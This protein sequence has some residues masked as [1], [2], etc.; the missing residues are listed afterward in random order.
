MIDKIKKLWKSLGPGLITGAADDDPSGVATYAMTG[1]RLGTGAVWMMLYSL[2]LMI[3]IQEMSA[4]IGLSS[5][6]GLA[7]NLKRYY[8]K[9]LLIFLSTLII[10]ANVLNI[11]AN[12]FGMASALELITPHSSQILSWVIV[13]FI[14]ILIVLLPYKKIVST[15]KWL[16]LTLFA[17]MFASFMIVENWHIILGQLLV[18][19][20]HLNKD[21][22]LLLMAVIGTTVA[23][24]MAFWQSSE[25]AEERKDKLSPSRALVCKFRIFSD[26]E[27]KRVRLDTRVGMFFS[28]FIAFFIIALTGSVLYEAGIKDIETVE[29]IA[30]ALKPLAGDYA[31]YLFAMGIIGAGLLT[32]PILAGSVGYILSEIFNWSGS[33]N[34]P[35][36]KAPE[37]Y[38]VII[39]SALIGLGI[40]YTGINAVDAL[41]YTAVLNGAI[42]P[43][44]IMVIIHMANNPAIVGPNINKKSDNIWGYI[45]FLVMT[46]LTLVVLTTQIPVDKAVGLIS[47]FVF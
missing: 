30:N 8:P 45:A 16:A 13:V 18:P 39:F 29:D 35:F 43:L 24:Y 38:M 11:G 40:P 10:S 22:F 28:N 12:V 41:F 32:I 37:F 25:E 5:S 6:C 4:R 46:G 44:L 33:L 21:F 47:S 7:G 2:P 17:Y 36:K 26:K 1:A 3:T 34:K 27:L 20:I 14:L 15:F 42:A 31:Y 23:P 9:A 19:E